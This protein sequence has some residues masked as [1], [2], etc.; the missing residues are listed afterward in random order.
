MSEAQQVYRITMT[1]NMSRKSSRCLRVSVLQKLHFMHAKAMWRKELMRSR[2]TSFRQNLNS[3]F[4]EA[5]RSQSVSNPRVQVPKMQ[6][7]AG[8]RKREQTRG[9]DS[10]FRSNLQPV[11]QDVSRNLW[12]STPSAPM[13][14]RQPDAVIRQQEL[15][16]EQET[17]I[18]Q[19]RLPVFQ[20]ITNNHSSSTSRNQINY[21]ANENCV[22]SKYT[23]KFGFG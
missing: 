9:R 21:S 1:K 15:L 3:A 16:R 10:S 14:R 19:N 17:S 20:N 4:Q 5:S 18:R 23:Y 6:Q 2:Q 12:G 7:D 8:I 11:F 13:T 22:P